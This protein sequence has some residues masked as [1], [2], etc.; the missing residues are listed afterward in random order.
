[1]LSV[2]VARSIEVH[3]LHPDTQRSEWRVD[4]HYLRSVLLIKNEYNCK[5]VVV[6]CLEAS[7]LGHVKNMSHV[8]ENEA[9]LRR[10]EC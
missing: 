4:G 6:P 1:M 2:E 8:F 10:W 3:W 5:F 7:C 9:T